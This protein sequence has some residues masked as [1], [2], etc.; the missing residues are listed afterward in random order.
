MKYFLISNHDIK[1]VAGLS[2]QTLY[3][4]YLA[5]VKLRNFDMYF[6]GIDNEMSIKKISDGDF[7]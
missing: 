5:A 7:N 2:A 6:Y 3:G 1:A 4:T